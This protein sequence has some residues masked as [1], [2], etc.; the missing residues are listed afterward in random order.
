MGAVIITTRGILW[1]VLTVISTILVF[2]AVITPR[3]LVGATRNSG[4][5]RGKIAAEFTKWNENSFKEHF[6]VAD[7]Q[8]FAFF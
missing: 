7:K 3:W 4:G 8:E 2:T 6:R 1:V 5:Y